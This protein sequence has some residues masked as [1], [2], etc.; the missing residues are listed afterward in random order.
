[1]QGFVRIRVI[2]VNPWLL[3]VFL[4]MARAHSKLATENSFCVLL[5]T[6]H[7]A[8]LTL[9]SPIPSLWTSRRWRIAVLLGIG[10]MINFF[11]RVNL[12]VAITPLRGEFGLSTVAVGYLLSTYSWT[13][14]MLQLPS[15]PV[16]DRYG[17]K[18]V[19][20]IS[21]F[22]W[23]VASFVTGLARGF[24]GM[25]AARLLLGVAE[26]PIF[27]S[28]AKAIGQWFPRSERGMSTAIFDASAKFASAVGV[29]MVAVVVHYWGW[30][31][32]FV[33]TGVLSLGYF[34]LFWI[35]YREPTEDPLLSPAEREHIAAGGGQQEAAV[36]PH[37][38]ASLWFLLRRKKVWGLALGMA[39]YSYNFYLFLTWLPG[40]LGTALNLNLMQSGFYTAIPWLAATVSDLLVGGWLVDYLIRLGHDSTRV[41]Q[42][43]LVLGLVLGLAVVGATQTTNPRVAIFWISI[44]LCGLAATAPIGWSIPGLIAPRGSIARV[45]GIM[46]FVSNVPAIL[47][48]VITGYLVGNS[49]SFTRAFLV[50]AAVLVGGILSYLFLLGRIETIPGPAPTTSA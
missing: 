14:V 43:I 28:N 42:S 23:S 35:I 37:H 4:R 44:A 40:Y 29:P 2:R 11:D 9:D 13:Y 45:G 25:I 8:A 20:R 10:V 6:N 30:R 19:I 46:N 32:S 3:L 22:L 21:T 15:G 27:P 5:P 31:M 7:P 12:S 18:P 39:A 38:T 1:V 33:F 17:V 16:L 48:P 24:T 41:R 50:A 36:D 26:A 47:A 49:H 34:A